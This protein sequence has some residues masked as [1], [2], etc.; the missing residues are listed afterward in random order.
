ME[1]VA[2]GSSHTCALDVDGTAY[3]WGRN[4]RGQL[5]RG[6][7]GGP[8]FAP[9]PVMAPA[10]VHLTADGHQTCGLTADGTAYCWGDNTEGQLG[11]P[12]Y[13]AP[14]AL[15]PIQ[16]PDMSFSDL[17]MGANHA[18]GLDSTGQPHCWGWNRFGEVGLPG[19]SAIVREPNP[20][21][22]DLRFEQVAA[23]WRHTCGVT[24]EGDVWCWGNNEGELLGAEDL[25][26]SHTPVKVPANP[27]VRI[28]AGGLHTCGI[29]R[30]GPTVCWGE[31]IGGLGTMDLDHCEPISCA[32]PVEVSGGHRF[33]QLAIGLTHTCALDEHGQ[34]YCWGE[35]QGGAIGNCEITPAWPTPQSVCGDARYVALAAGLNHSCGV[36]SDQEGWCWGSNES[37]QLG[38]TSFTSFGPRLVSP[39]R[40]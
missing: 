29:E 36:S 20:V 9:E 11:N 32:V 31:R 4:D 27:M 22:T 1:V 14:A 35:S 17:D 21:P 10:L 25:D 8:A 13:T 3:C 37:L 40:P 30:A 5:G 19:D 39:A 18:C 38:S 2:A 7:I 33:L 23:A 12:N 16:I 34:A 24:G 28:V 6:T 26:F 15:T